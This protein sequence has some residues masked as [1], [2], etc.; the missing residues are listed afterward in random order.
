M[1][2]QTVPY[3]EAP[4]RL[5]Y[6]LFKLN[7]RADG[8]MA[9]VL[10]SIN[11]IG[12]TRFGFAF[13]FP[14]IAIG[15]WLWW[16]LLWSRRYY[17]IGEYV[18][19]LW[20]RLYLKDTLWED[21]TKATDEAGQP[22][23]KP[24]QDIL[25]RHVP[26]P[27]RV[28]KL[29]DIGLIYNTVTG[30]DSIVIASSG[31][32]IAGMSLMGMHDAQEVIASV[33]RRI[34]NYSGLTAE[35]SFGYR[36]R[37]YSTSEIR[38]AYDQNAYPDILVPAALVPMAK[39]GQTLEELYEQGLVSKE[40]VRRARLGAIVAES[41]ALANIE[42]C[43][44]D[45]VAVITIQRPPLLRSA[46]KG[47]AE[48][49]PR[50]ALRTTIVDMALDVCDALKRAT[51]HNPH[52]LDQLECE[53]Y[54]RAAWDV[55]GLEAYRE[56]RDQHIAS[57][58]E[59][60]APL[61]HPQFGIYTDNSSCVTD[62]TGHVTVRLT[63]LPRDIVPNLMPALF[64][65]SGVRWPSV[66]VIGESTTGN[67]EYLRTSWFASIF[68]SVLDSLGFEFGPKTRNRRESLDARQ[69]ELAAKGHTEYFDV[70][71]SAASDDPEELEADLARL[72]G[73]A[74][75]VGALATVVTG[76]SRQFRAM[77]TATTCIGLL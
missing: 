42:G 64:S 50:E 13:L 41:I 74:K 51:V 22:S 15:L 61:Y 4:T 23:K 67:A 2:G 20:I 7:H 56:E 19:S 75:S 71:L 66:S 29:H 53:D 27:L 49:T 70:Y 12:W 11:L 8:R 48:V 77:L 55:A 58:A 24:R 35:V 17:A 40:D 73:V 68:D 25:R 54:L 65:D 18:Y 32:D 5:S 59:G 30:T 46:A 10:I 43:D 39:T 47:K 26:M 76:R 28:D 63:Q 45:M 69:E 36:R 31:S 62:Q 37:P 52:I 16:P 9:L 33:I 1:E 72:L 34:A 38:V 3:V 14:G 21:W 6:D 60:M 57:E 44:V